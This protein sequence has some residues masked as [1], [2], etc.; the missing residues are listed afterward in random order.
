MTTLGDRIREQR[1]KKGFTQK[2]LAELI[3]AK[4]NSIS[5]WE[6]NKSKPDSNTIRLLMKA[7]EVDANSLLGYDDKESI[8]SEAAKLADNILNNPKITKMLSLLINMPDED[9]SLVIAF[10]ERLNKQNS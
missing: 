1:I 7:L 8:K 4:H 6:N 3:G 5:D 2:Q 10:A 9:L